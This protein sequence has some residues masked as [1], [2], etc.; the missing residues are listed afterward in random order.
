MSLKE[1]RLYRIEEFRGAKRSKEGYRGVK[2][3][4]E[5]SRGV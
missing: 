2:R 5:E 1:Y 3:S 4:I